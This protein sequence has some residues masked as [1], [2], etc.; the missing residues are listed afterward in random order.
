MSNTAN[1][2]E[3]E[4]LLKKLAEAESPEALLAVM[5]E[6]N[7][8]LEEGL[9]AEEFFDTLHAPLEDELSED[10][11]TDVS[12]GLRMPNF[13][14]IQGVYYVGKALINYLRKHPEILNPLRK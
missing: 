10:D 6:N 14:V 8:A 7:M 3:N 12:G 11:L 9:S 5:A 2:L 1:I 13:L 4:E